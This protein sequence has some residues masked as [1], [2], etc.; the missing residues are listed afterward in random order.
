M[1]LVRNQSNKKKTWRAY[2]TNLVT[3]LRVVQ[4][5]GKIIVLPQSEENIVKMYFPQRAFH[6]NSCQ[7]GISFTHGW[8]VEVQ[9]FVHLVVDEQIHVIFCRHDIIY[10]ARPWILVTNSQEFVKLVTLKLVIYLFACLSCWM[11]L[12]SAVNEKLFS[13]LLREENRDDLVTV[14]KLNGVL[15]PILAC[16]CLSVDLFRQCWKTNVVWILFIVHSTYQDI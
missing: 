11:D 8:T 16:W 5:F 10:I 6:A 4:N 12:L 9:P 3:K 15:L 7:I 13:L 14:V 2:N 1:L